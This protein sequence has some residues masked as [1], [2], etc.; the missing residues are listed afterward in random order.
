VPHLQ[1]LKE[2]KVLKEDKERKVLK[3]DKEPKDQKVLKG[4]KVR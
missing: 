1:E 4:L 2:P 3:E